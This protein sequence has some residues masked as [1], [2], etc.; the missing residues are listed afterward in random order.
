M[1][2]WDLRDLNEA[3]KRRA[4]AAKGPRQRASPASLAMFGI[5]PPKE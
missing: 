3:R 2:W 4:E 5:A 1:T